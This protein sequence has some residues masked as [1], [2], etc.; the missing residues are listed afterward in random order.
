[1]NRRLFLGAV[2]AAGLTPAQAFAV[3]SKAA[4]A[5]AAA[6]ASAE[7]GGKRLLLVFHASWCGYCQ[8]MDMMLEDAACKAILD[9]YFVIYHLRAL[10]AKPE[11]KA[12]QLDGAD[13]V[14]AGLTPKTT[15]LPYVAV[16]DGKA[17]RVTDSIMRNGDN[18][19]FPVDAV[20]LDNF[21]DMMRKGAPEMSAQE[22]KTLRRTCVRIFK[23]S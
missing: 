4:E 23:Q 22:V 11:M 17:G 8:L 13:E 5:V 16:L 21:Q 19:G 18:F 9:K 20:E 2:I 10:E 6:A 3:E 1:M 14:Y 7:A 15:G 12:Q